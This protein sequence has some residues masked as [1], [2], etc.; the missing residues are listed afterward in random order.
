MDN[1]IRQIIEE[2][3]NGNQTAFG[4]I[5]R[6]FQA[7]LRMFVRVLLWDHEQIDD[8]TQQAFITAYTRIDTYD[9]E[10]A[11]FYV[12][13][14]GIARNLAMNANRRWKT[15]RDF[16][17]DYFEEL[18]IESASES[19]GLDNSPMDIAIERLRS[20]FSRLSPKLQEVFRAFY[21]LGKR[22]ADIA[23]ECHISESAVKM[24]LLRGRL[25]LKTCMDGLKEESP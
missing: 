19:A 11:E 7:R 13:L 15:R 8:L 17:S 6:R 23:V 9:P 12:W 14:K 4:E 24:T 10:K 3:Q 2:V 21:D 22:G 5:V 25:A 16:Q 20:C 18:R 1:E